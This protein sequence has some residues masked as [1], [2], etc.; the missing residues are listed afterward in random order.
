MRGL[1]IFLYAIGAAKRTVTCTRFFTGK[2]QLTA[3]GDPA[4]LNASI[5]SARVCNLHSA[6]FNYPPAPD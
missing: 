1:R 3:S 6:F 4:I 5:N 2:C